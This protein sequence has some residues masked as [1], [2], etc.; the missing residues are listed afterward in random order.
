MIKLSA[1]GE[2]L[3]VEIIGEDGQQRYAVKFGYE[4][5]GNLTFVLAGS[6]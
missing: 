5:I 3:G 2:T 6:K 4:A 1:N